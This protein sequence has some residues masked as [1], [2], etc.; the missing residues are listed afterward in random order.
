MPLPGVQ[1]RIVD[2][3]NPKSEREITQEGESGELR[4]KGPA[5]FSTYWERPE[6]TATAFDG[7]GYFKTG[8]TTSK[9]YFVTLHQLLSYLIVSSF[10][11]IYSPSSPLFLSS[12][13]RRLL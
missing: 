4:V 8:D 12:C 2:D 5:V 1:V 13:N 6:A 9:L 7:Q 3:S 10:V 11:C